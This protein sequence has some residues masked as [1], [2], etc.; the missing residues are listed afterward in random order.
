M[1]RKRPFTVGKETSPVVPTVS[2]SVGCSVDTDQPTTIDSERVTGHSRY[3]CPRTRG[4]AG[5]E[6]R[7]GGLNSLTSR[8]VKPVLV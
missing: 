6:S 3:F 7:T 8:N 1:V 4:G 5:D 2:V